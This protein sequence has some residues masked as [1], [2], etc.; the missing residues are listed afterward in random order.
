MLKPD[1]DDPLKLRRIMALGAAFNGFY[2]VVPMVAWLNIK[3]HMSV[4]LCESIL[5]YAEVIMTG[6]IAPYLYGIH[7]QGQE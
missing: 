7:K 5:H 3:C 1:P 2:G 4:D 6:L